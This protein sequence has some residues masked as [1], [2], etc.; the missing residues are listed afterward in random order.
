MTNV[1]EETF[2]DIQVF[3]AQDRAQGRLASLVYNKAAGRFEVGVENIGEYPLF[4]R[5][6]LAFIAEG[7]NY[8]ITSNGTVQVD[9]RGSGVVFASYNLD[10]AGISSVNAVMVYGERKEFLV[11]RYEKEFP[12]SLAFDMWWLLIIPLLLILALLYAVY[13][14]VSE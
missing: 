4:C 3:S 11:N 10:T 7:K 12:F 14:R 6:E 8:T 13:R 2:R 5:V 1:Y 9:P